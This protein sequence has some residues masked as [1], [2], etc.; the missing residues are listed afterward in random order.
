MLMDRSNEAIVNG[1]RIQIGILALALALGPSSG[2]RPSSPARRPISRVDVDAKSPTAT[3]MKLPLRFEANAGQWDARVRFVTRS[4]GTTLFLTDDAMTLQ[5]HGASTSTAVTMRLANVRPSAPVGESILGTKSN[6]FLGNDPAHWRTDVPNFA[7]VR[8]KEWA[9]GV[10]VVWHGGAKGLE[11]DLDVAAGTDA[12]RIAFDIEGA[13]AIAL[14][15]DGSLAIETPTGRLTQLP[16]RV[17]QNGSELATRYRIEGERRVAFDLEGYDPRKPVLID[18]T[19]AFSTYLGGNASDLEYNHGSI[20]VGPGGAIFVG[21]LS[22]STNYPLANPIQGSLAGANDVVITEL[23]PGGAGLVYSTYLGGS[24]EE[25]CYDIAVDSSGNAHVVGYTESANYP[26]SNAYST[27]LNGFRDAFVAKLGPTGSLLYSTYLGGNKA[28]EAYGVAIGTNGAAYVTGGTSSANFPTT[29]GA[30]QTT[31]PGGGPFV[32]ELLPSGG[33]LVFSTFVGTYAYANAIAVDS[34][35]AT[36]ITGDVASGTVPTVNAFQTTNKGLSDVFVSK[37]DPTGSTLVYSTYLGGTSSDYGNGIAVDGTGAAYVTGSTLSTNF[38]TTPTAYT[39]TIGAGSDR[40][41][42]AKF[43]PS[44]SSLAYSTFIGHATGGAQSIA[45]D[46]A[47]DAIGS[48]VITGKTGATTFP[49]YNAFQPTLAGSWDAF[50]TKLLPTGSGV[51]YSTFLGGSGADLGYGVALDGAGDVYV[52]GTT[53]SVNFP[54][55]SPYQATNGGNVDLYVAKITDG[56]LALGLTPSST[57]VAPKGSKTFSAF[58]GSGTG[59][60][61]SFS[62]NASGGTINASTGAYVAGSTP[63]VIDVVRVTDSANAVATANVTV[64]PGVSLSP[65]APTVAPKSTIAFAASGGSGSGF[66]WSLSTNA[67]GGTINPSTGAYVAGATGSVSDIVHVIDALGNSADANVTVSAGVAIAPASPSCTPKASIAFSAS[68]GSGGGYTWSLTTNSSGATINA[69][70]GAYV[71]GATGNVVDTLSV[72]D[73]LG[74][75]AATAITVGPTVVVTPNAPSTPPKGSI[76]FAASGGSG[77]GYTWSL[78]TNASGGT[79]NSSSGVYVAGSTGNVNDTVTV[80]DSLGNVGSTGISVGAGIA[81][82]PSTPSTPPKGAIAFSATGGSGVGYTWALTTNASGA[83]LNASSGAYVAGA[84]GGVSDVV[85]VTDSLGNAASVS[86]SVGAGISISPSLPSTP[87]KGAVSFSAVG[88]SGIGYLWSIGPNASGATI[89]STGEYV[90]GATGNVVDTVVVTDSLG[91]SASANVSVGGGLAINPA[92]PSVP[93]KGAVSFFVQG[94]SSAGYVW[95]LTTNASGAKMDSSTGAY[96][97]G[98]KGNVTDAVAVTDSVGNTAS[99]D[100]T[101]TAGLSLSP[102]NPKVAS[103]ATITFSAAGGSGSGYTWS[104]ES[105]ASGGT[106]TSAG[107]YTAGT[108]PGVDTIRLVDSL[109]NLATTTASVERADAG[110]DAGTVPPSQESACGCAVVGRAPTTGGLASFGVLLVAVVWRRRANRR[111]GK[112]IRA[113]GADCGGSSPT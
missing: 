91:N 31:T 22:Q 17:L 98:A 7:Q 16:P 30:F 26:T 72:T 78:S 33:S 63:S 23:S 8:A 44:G 10:D 55:L 110:A 92:K 52:T 57:T 9:P 43:A 6:F 95:S 97:A 29:S 13:N 93:P 34:T 5:L 49:V 65:A 32:T 85:A 12:S 19:L 111:I 4:N 75:V 11:Y 38:P 62:T 112:D 56:P 53:S 84:M 109:G 88:G 20:A 99:V 77:T 71:A 67:S 69:S 70:N 82:A 103:G 37:L 104:L 46:I 40:S 28:D 61:Y 76:A 101:V 36:Y 21:A 3:S 18:P 106:I 15:A 14:T 39:P 64:G 1:T 66:T 51:A 24:A 100:V 73:S 27:T 54:T 59:Y 68:G 79:I 102:Q 41:F 50:I 48:A 87:P 42:V 107:V 80:T 86:V 108:N 2:Q 35:G 90:A 58:G 45:Y 74:N 105:S 83:T 47:V 25:E 94:G 96:T 89:K 113:L 81:L 60:S